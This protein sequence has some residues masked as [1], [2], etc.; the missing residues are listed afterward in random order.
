MFLVFLNTFKHILKLKVARQGAWV[1]NKKASLT[2]HYR[3]VPTEL[4]ATLHA[5][6]EAIILSL[7]FIAN[8]AH[9]AVEA[10]PAVNWNKG[11][12]YFTLVKAKK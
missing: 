8:R 4:Q 11:D 7:G 12:A 5:E 10:K 9:C 3:E 2:F 6:A 1:E